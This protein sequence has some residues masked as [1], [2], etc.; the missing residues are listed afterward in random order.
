MKTLCF[1]WHCNFI[2]YIQE[3]Y[4]WLKLT[5]N[6]F[7]LHL[8]WRLHFCA[9]ILAH[10]MSTVGCFC[11]YVGVLIVQVSESLNSSG[12]W[13][14]GAALSHCLYLMRESNNPAFN[15]PWK[16]WAGTFYAA[17]YKVCHRTIP[18]L[19][20]IYVSKYSSTYFKQSVLFKNVF[21]RNSN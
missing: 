5:K 19:L 9:G 18:I 17:V 1:Y 20:H 6:T 21:D 3:T 16:Y 7:A 10:V 8:N 14:R 4:T 2:I 15:L 12:G 11:F 13:P